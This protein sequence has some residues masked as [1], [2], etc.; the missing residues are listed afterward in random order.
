V[1]VLLDSQPAHS[2][3]SFSPARSFVDERA[4]EKGG[5]GGIPFSFAR[6]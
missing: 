3:M 1:T 5:E 4:G 6:S 2:V